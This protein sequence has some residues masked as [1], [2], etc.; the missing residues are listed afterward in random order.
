MKPREVI[1]Q[2]WMITVREN[3]LRHWGFFSA[4]LETMLNAKLLMYQIWFGYSLF[5]VGEPI[6]FFEMEEYL[7]SI[8]P[9]WLF[10]TLA[11]AFVILI[12]C[13]WVVPHMAKGAIIG[14][15]AKSYLGEP[16]RGGLVLAMYNFFPLFGAHE[17][18]IF[19]SIPVCITIASLILRYLGPAAPFALMMLV[20]VWLVSNLAEFFWIFAEE[21]IVIRKSGFKEA[22]SDSFKLVISFLS[23]I[24]FLILLLFI[25]VLRIFANLILV[26]IV[27]GIV[28]GL[29]F[30]L[31]NFVF[32]PAAVSY[33]LSTV[34]GMVIIGFASYFFAYIEV[35]RQTVWTITYIELKKEREL[36]LI[37]A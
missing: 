8:L 18:L 35:F 23:H 25:I 13:E 15:G 32:L 9:L 21:A 1:A 33:S 17:L 10:I 14:L 4:I 20:T 31:T 6:G 22:F 16:V 19:S 26:L 7:L 5:I 27:P 30:L 11:I 2:A 36:D 24:V 28:V 37:E 29:G 3:K 12:L 34:L